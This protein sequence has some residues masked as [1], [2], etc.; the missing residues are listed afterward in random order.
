MANINFSALSAIY[1]SKNNLY[2][3]KKMTRI[4]EQLNIQTKTS[5]RNWFLINIVELNFASW[6]LDGIHRMK[7]FVVNK[8]MLLLKLYH[9]V[10]YS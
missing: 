1:E 6:R 10:S 4:L 7:T 5:L 3:D 2:H 9:N 8:I